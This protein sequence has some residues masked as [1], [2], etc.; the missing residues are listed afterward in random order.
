MNMGINKENTRSII[1]ILHYSEEM[2]STTH[3]TITHI[4]RPQPSIQERKTYAI[5]FQN[6]RDF[7]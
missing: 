2:I 6:L 5:I 7:V 4:G 3:L 1:I